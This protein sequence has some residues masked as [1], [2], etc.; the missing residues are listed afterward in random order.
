MSD[1]ASPA[2]AESIPS[3]RRMARGVPGGASLTRKQIDEYG[4]VGIEQV[5]GKTVFFT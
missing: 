5:Y 4:K 2:V 1:C 3:A